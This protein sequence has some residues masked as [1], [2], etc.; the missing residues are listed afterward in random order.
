M[1][2]DMNELNSYS[3]KVRTDITSP[4][5]N[6]GMV[7][8]AADLNGAMQYPV[9]LFQA[10]VRAYFGCGVVCGL[11][12]EEYPRPANMRDPGPNWWLTIHPGTALD[13][14]GYPL[15]I[16][17]CQKISLKPDPCSCD[18][19]PTKVCIAVRRCVVNEAPRDDVDPC[20]PKGA[21]Q[22]RR[23]REYVEIKVFDPTDCDLPY[24]CR[25]DPAGDQRDST[26]DCLKE[27]PECHC[28]ECWVELACV[29]LDPCDGIV[30]V[31]DCRQ[32]VKPI[33]CECL[34]LGAEPGCDPNA[35][36][37]AAAVAGPA[38]RKKAKKK[39]SKK[40]RS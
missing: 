33:H 36:P 28:G 4:V 15:K 31:T 40:T 19:M 32:W 9:E 30:G 1:D 39:V 13:C 18:P 5:F 22:H 24:I 26:C 12:V 2:K 10:L 20:D 16:C 37:A 7:V 25:R 38:A 6:D 11:K 3:K 14:N 21:D 17:E 8:T 23:S 35:E 27:C 34:P 29:T